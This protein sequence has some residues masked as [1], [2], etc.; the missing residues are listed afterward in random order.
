[1]F[2]E[3]DSELLAARTAKRLGLSLTDVFGRLEPVCHG[4]ANGCECEGCEATQKAIARRGFTSDGL[5]RASDEPK[6]P[7]EEQ[8]A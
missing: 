8:A 2:A 7:W 4:Y 1:M 6:Q 5:I 3:P